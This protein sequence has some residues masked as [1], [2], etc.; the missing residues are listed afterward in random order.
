[1]KATLSSACIL[2]LVLGLGLSLCVAAPGQTE[3]LA[4]PY[5][6]VSGEINADTTWSLAESPYVVTGDVTVMPGVTLT[7][8]PGVQVRFNGNYVLGVRGTLIAE[9]LAGQ[10]ILFTSNLASPAAGD[11]GV[12]DFRS[13]SKYSHVQYAIIEYGGNAYKP[14]AYCATGAVC[15]NTSSF[16]MED[17]SVRHSPTRG[18]SLA[19]SSATLANNTFEHITW[20]AIRLH[21]CDLNIGECHPTIVGNDFSYTQY[22]ILHVAP[23]NPV[24]SG[25]AATNNQING[26]VFYVSCNVAGTNTWYAGDLPYVVPAAGGWCLMGVYGRPTTV[27]IQPGTIVKLENSLQFHYSTVVTATGTAEAP[28]IFTS[29]KDDSAGGDTNNDGAASSPAKRD[30]GMIDHFGDQVRGTYEHAIF[31]YGGGYPAAFGP[32][33]NSDSGATVIV[34]QSVISQSGGAGA[35]A[36]NASNLTLVESEIYDHRD[37]CIEVAT[38]TGSVLIENNRIQGCPSGVLVTKGSPTIRGNYFEG[39]GVGVE[40]VNTFQAAPVV[41][42]HNRF[43]GTGQMGVKNRYPMDGCIDA[44]RNWWGDVSGPSDTSTAT[45]ACGMADNPEGIGASVSDGVNYYPWE[46][47]LPRPIIA[48]PGCGVTARDK[49]TFSGRAAEGATVSFY[50]NGVLLGQTIAAADDS[51]TWSPPVPLLD[52]EH[53][54]SAVAELDGESSLPTPRLPLEVYSELPFDPMGVLISYDLHGHQYTQRMRDENGCATLEGSLEMPI[55]VRPGTDFTVSVPMRSELLPAAGAPAANEATSQAPA[56]PTLPDQPV[57]NDPDAPLGTVT[58]H[59]SNPNGATSVRI[60]SRTGETMYSDFST[61]AS[62][63]NMVISDTRTI[64]LPEG[65]YDFLFFSGSANVVDRQQRSVGGTSGWL[66]D[67]ANNLQETLA[68]YNDSGKDF[69]EMY[70]TT[71]HGLEGQYIGGDFIFDANTI[72]NGKSF[73]VKLPHNQVDATLVMKDADGAYYIRYSL[74]ISYQKDAP[75]LAMMSFDKPSTSVTVN[76]G[77][78]KE[79][80]YFNVISHNE[81]PYVKKLPKDIARRRAVDIMELTGQAVIIKGETFTFK[82]ESGSYYIAAYDCLGNLLGEWANAEVTGI[83]KTFNIVT[84]CTPPGTVKVGEGG[85]QSFL[86]SADLQCEAAVDGFAECS[87]SSAV[88]ASELVLDLCYEP[89]EDTP[90]GWELGVG[91]LKIDPDG[92]VY[93]AD[94]GID[95]K[96]T[97][98][99]VTCEVYD[100][101]YQAWS[102]WPA[103]F[104]ESQLNPQTTASDGYYAFFVPPGLYRV[105]AGAPGYAG[106]TS[107]DIQVVSEIVHYNIPLEPTGEP[108]SGAIYL[109]L[110]IH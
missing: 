78:D 87:A 20:E 36:Y 48:S 57:G 54:L 37:T 42:P 34:R 79:L 33:L 66:V 2:I 7:I 30:W 74:P 47:N 62:L 53:N 55:W 91:A 44:R 71:D 77:G 90:T 31:R 15:V 110:I 9:G 13:D 89:P 3:A 10:E 21:A 82:L 4:A 96:V 1:M 65:D 29:L 59:N 25:N 28:V 12:L 40:V 41:S 26:Y 69:T 88:S 100:E 86:E 105:T 46:G 17:S 98:A 19:Q 6:D 23:L 51:F 73:D 80:C 50:D 11:W 95:S 32:T 43:V 45:D 83:S 58:I 24:L 56:A 81:L 99:T 107:P 101:D 38:T 106:H 104:Y 94:L 85:L 93:N 68:I 75:P 27:N 67:I 22:P 39:N 63:D 72:K 102:E 109:P 64:D 61:R 16:V 8:E 84:P 97:G 18:V 92:Y 76:Y 70:Y 49:P 5:T 103:A 14:G 35:H 60:A 108:P 52:G